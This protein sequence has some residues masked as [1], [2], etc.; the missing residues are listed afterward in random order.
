M[1][2]W[3]R[4]LFGSSAPR[5]ARRFLP[6]IVTLEDRCT[7]SL[8][9]V[10]SINTTNVNTDTVKVATSANGNSVAVYT[11]EFGAGD[12][13]VYARRINATGSLVGSE[14]TVSFSSDD[15]SQPDVAIDDSGNFVIVW[16]QNDANTGDL[17]VQFKVYDSTG[18][19]TVS[20][21]VATSN[22][23][24]A[25]RPRV[26]MSAT[27]KWVVAFQTSAVEGNDIYARLYDLTGLQVGKTIAVSASVLLD[28][29]NPAIDCND[30]GAFAISY[31]KG[32]TATNIYALY[33]KRFSSSGKLLGTT[34]VA[35][36]KVTNNTFRHDIAIRNNG[37]TLVAYTQTQGTLNTNIFARTI[38]VLGVV[39]ARKTLYTSAG[40]A[41]NPAI[42]FNRLTGKF[43]LA[44][45]DGSA[46]K[47]AE[48]KANITPAASVIT[49]TPTATYSRPAA[50]MNKSGHYF[51]SFIR[52]VGTNDNDPE[53]ALGTLV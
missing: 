50:S 31:E 33:A 22:G 43:V 46:I 49:L 44:T 26:A 6:E 42:A 32:D 17:D 52:L 2:S 4:R 34:T 53:G 11:R 14:I 51:I 3:F 37:T 28:D 19:Q 12:R 7:P 36:N 13:D 25:S 38:T 30:S 40:I 39:G 48:F 5:A 8:G 10:F 1:S 47:V 23:Y 15:Q 29:T 16:T 24:D 41:D 9:S 27:G 35:T 18:A 20:G 45:N 21:G